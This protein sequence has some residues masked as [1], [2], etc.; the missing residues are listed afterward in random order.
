MTDRPSGRWRLS[1][2][3]LA[4]LVV[5]TLAAALAVAIGGAHVLPWKTEALRDSEDN[6]AVAT[7]AEKGVEAFLDVDYRQIDDRSARVLELST[8]AFRRQYANRATDLRIATM[9]AQSVSTS[10][11]RAVGVHRVAAERATVL[12]AAD[13]VLSSTATKKLKPTKSCPRAGVRC[14]HFRFLVTLTRVG[15]G[16]LMSDLAEVV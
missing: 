5:L 7:A 3:L 9:R 12:V 14:Q 4:Q 10:T 11:I 13:S 6:R 15:H 8:G 2:V 1:D 16:W